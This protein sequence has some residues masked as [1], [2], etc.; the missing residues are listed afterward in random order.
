MLTIVETN[1]SPIINIHLWTIVFMIFV[2]IM[3]EKWPLKGQ[4]MLKYLLSV[5]MAASRGSLGGGW[6]NYDEQ[7]RLKKLGFQL[8]PGLTWTWN[9]GYCAYLPQ[10]LIITYSL[11]KV[12]NSNCFLM[13]N[14]AKR[15][16]VLFFF[17]NYIIVDK[18]VNMENFAIL[19][20]VKFE[21]LCKS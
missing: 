6:I 7:F 18:D 17:A 9:H 19:C 8:R 12:D 1:K 3:L 10:R 2:D 4:E 15:T 13:S 21:L 11:S 14:V 5:R 16:G 20:F